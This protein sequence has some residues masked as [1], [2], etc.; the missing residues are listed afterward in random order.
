MEIGEYLEELNNLEEDVLE[1][2]VNLDP[3][4]TGLPYRVWSEENGVARNNKHNDPRIKVYVGNRDYSVIVDKNNPHLSKDSKKQL[5]D[6]T[7][8]GFDKIKKFIIL[9]YDILIDHW[10]GLL[11]RKLFI[12]KIKNRIKNVKW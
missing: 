4:L 11:D 3:E 1:E 8:R 9:C 6:G 2:K 12:N 5:K 7:F 10:N